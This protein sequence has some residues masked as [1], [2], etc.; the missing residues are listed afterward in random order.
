MKKLSAQKYSIL[1]PGE[2]WIGGQPV[3]Y[4][5]KKYT[6]P[7]VDA[8]GVLAD[9][10][11]SEENQDYIIDIEISGIVYTINYKDGKGKVYA[12]NIVH[13]NDINLDKIFNNLIRILT[14]GGIP[15]LNSDAIGI[16]VPRIVIPDA[17]KRVAKQNNIKNVDADGIGYYIKD[18]IIESGPGFDL[19]GPNY[20]S[21]ASTCKE[22]GYENPYIDY[23]SNYVC[24]QCKQM[25]DWAKSAARLAKVIKRASLDDEP[26]PGWDD[27]S[28]FEAMDERFMRTPEFQEWKKEFFS[29]P[30]DV[31]DWLKEH[32]EYE[33]VIQGMSHKEVANFVRNEMR[34]EKRIK[35]LEEWVNKQKA[36]K[37]DKS[38]FYKYQPNES[39]DITNLDEF[40]FVTALANIYFKKTAAKE[41]RKASGF[42]LICPKTK[43]LF[44]VKRAQNVDSPGTWCTVGGG[45]EKGEDFMQA[46][47]RECVEELGS[48]PEISDII[49]D[50]DSSMVEDLVYKTFVGVVSP[51]TRENWK[52]KLNP[53]NDEFGWFKPNELPKPL[54]PGLA[55][56]LKILKEKYAK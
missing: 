16:M 45:V 47:K 20:D 39:L 26:Y 22:C 33:P 43:E 34:E 56:T 1:G 18:G 14:I 30:K 19:I 41:K 37:I 44:L 5:I 12:G 4:D 15:A 42:L 27:P 40:N 48:C 52:P 25:V 8:N 50:I 6:S 31:A 38:I 10:N 49:D 21:K 17:I 29:Y 3:K 53:E 2:V 24:R 36:P 9:K 55:Y 46:A 23:D 11:Q 32:P 54:H 35:D 7:K 51:E 28:E 13:S